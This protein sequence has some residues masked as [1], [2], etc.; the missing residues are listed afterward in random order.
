VGGVAILLFFFYID[1]VVLLIGAEINSEIDF[2]M[3]ITRGALD[4]RKP[5]PSVAQEGD[6]H[7]SP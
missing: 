3:G 4:F 1:A 5:A 2:A 7:A 6:G